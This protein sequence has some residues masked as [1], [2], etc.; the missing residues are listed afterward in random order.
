MVPVNLLRR[1]IIFL[2]QIGLLSVLF[3][4]ASDLTG[5]LLQST[6]CSLAFVSDERME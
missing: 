5:G 4:P 3:K 6:I 2:V 1:G